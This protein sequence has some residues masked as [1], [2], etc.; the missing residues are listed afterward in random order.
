MDGELVSA[1]FGHVHSVFGV[2]A[3]VEDVGPIGVGGGVYESFADFVEGDGAAPDGS[4]VFRGEGF[5]V[6]GKT[7]AEGDVGAE[8]GVGEGLEWVS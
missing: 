8:I 7:G 3:H 5:F 6:E 2:A 4:G 1:E